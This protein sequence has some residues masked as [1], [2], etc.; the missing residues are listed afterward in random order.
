MTL[1]VIPLSNNL[2]DQ[3]AA[4]VLITDLSGRIL[5][6]NSCFLE[7][8]GYSFSEVLGKRIEAFIE[9]LE[10]RDD[11][12]AEE[13][14][15]LK[16]KD[17]E[18]VPQQIFANLMNRTVNGESFH[19]WILKDYPMCGYDPLT[20]LPN[21]HYLDKK[22]NKAIT[23]ARKNQSLFAVL[24]LDLD[25]FKFVNDTFGHSCGDQ[26]LQEVSYRMKQAVGSTHT[27]ARM[28]GDEFVCLA[29][30]LEDEREAEGIAKR[31]IDQ[32]SL[33]FSLKETELYMTT[34]IGISLYPFD[35]DEADILLTN[36]DSAM[37]GA[38]KR[39][40]NQFAKAKAEW[41]AGSFEKLLMES[42]LRK[43]IKEEEFLLYFQPQVNVKNNQI[44]SM[45]A[46]IRWNHPDLG[47]LMPGEF[48]PIAE[49]SGLILQIGD[50]VLR[51]A[52]Q[53]MKEWLNDG[54]V[55]IRVAV[56]L[57]AG[58]FLQ[59]DF[60]EKVKRILKETSLSAAHLE[61]E[62]T[63]NM[64]MNDVQ[65]AIQVLRQLKEL[66][67]YLSI[68]DFGTG[69]SSLN[70]LKEFTVDT[71]KIDRSFI[72][73]IEEDPNSVALTKAITTL[74]H[75]LK[76]NVVAEGVET[77]KQLKLVKQCSCDFVQGYY[78]SKPLRYEEAVLYIQDF[79]TRTGT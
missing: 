60:V 15:L 40:R 52:C 62:I 17:K 78:F 43:A 2:L 66:G 46:L 4:S 63:E 6:V 27:I 76:L 5:K 72:Y 13:E 14:I 68:D 49:E 33:P 22:I 26:L 29:E 1:G 70:Y 75:D 51:Q 67:V 12:M 32:F 24:F 59:S 36:A 77:F 19:I 53:K 31:I 39:G 38:K 61:L 57:A 65:T 25:R 50:W 8:S 11:I 23:R 3:I 20:N 10:D 55:P 42:S 73:D 56:N 54:N 28:G 79:A 64:V 9:G 16:T 69:Y 35:G 45:E 48:I 18:I 47:L 21:R 74:A 37:Y 44:T 41:N 34:S 71:L 58:Q 7:K 30:N